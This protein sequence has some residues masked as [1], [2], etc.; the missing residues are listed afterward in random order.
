M[1]TLSSNDESSDS[2]SSMTDYDTEDEIEPN[3]TPIQLT[4]TT[5][6]KPTQTKILK[7]SSLP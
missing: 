7:A 1:D 6:P 4:P 3:V 5:K 2:D